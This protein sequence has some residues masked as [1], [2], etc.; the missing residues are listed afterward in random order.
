VKLLEH[1]HLHSCGAKQSLDACTAEFFASHMHKLP[2]SLGI[3]EGVMGI[4]DN[5]EVFRQCGKGM[6]F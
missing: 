6:R 4:V 2:A 1:I 5:A 3:S